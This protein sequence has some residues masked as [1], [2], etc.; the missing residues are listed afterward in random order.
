MLHKNDFIEDHSVSGST[1]RFRKQMRLQSEAA[2]NDDTGEGEVVCSVCL[3]MDIKGRDFRF[4]QIQLLSGQRVDALR[5]IC[6]DGSRQ[7]RFAEQSHNTRLCGQR[8][9]KK[10]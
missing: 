10:T 7:N 1:L 8:H 3:P 5:S 6:R 2:E 9:D 4:F